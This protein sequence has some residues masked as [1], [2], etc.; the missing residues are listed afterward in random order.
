MT[1]DPELDQQRSFD[2][3]VNQLIEAGSSLCSSEFG[4]DLMASISGFSKEI[5]QLR[6]LAATSTMAI[7]GKPVIENDFYAMREFIT[8]NQIE[9]DDKKNSIDINSSGRI[10]TLYY[11][12]SVVNN[13]TPLGA[14][15]ALKGLSLLNCSAK[16]LS[17]LS[18][19]R[20]L[21]RVSLGHNRVLCVQSLTELQSIEYLSIT[22]SVI[23][24]LSWIALMPNLKDLSL[25]RNNIKDIGAIAANCQLQSL[26]FRGN[27]IA[28]VEP[29]RNLPCLETL[30]LSYTSVKDLSPLLDIPNLSFLIL[31]EVMI[32]R[33]NQLGHIQ[34]LVKKGVCIVNQ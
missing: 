29:L 6:T 11:D 22:D 31:D 15:T 26:V 13:V 4:S 32:D 34:E 5:H 33:G 20:L 8:I 27:P 12:Q 7:K 14:L 1:P 2:R 19:L 24:D 16:D 17:S 21:E 30:N 28:S 25:R 23:D 18:A 10:Y 9:I 3:L